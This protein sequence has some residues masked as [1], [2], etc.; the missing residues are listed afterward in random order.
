MTA[1]QIETIRQITR[2]HLGID[3]KVYRF[4]CRVDDK[5]KVFA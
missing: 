3:A 5:A 4:S 2:Q 1:T